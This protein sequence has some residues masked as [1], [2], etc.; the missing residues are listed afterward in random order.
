MSAH[1]A[2][3]GTSPLAE[4]GSSPLGQT[5]VPTLAHKAE[6]S[7]YKLGGSLLRFWDISG[8]GG[9]EEDLLAGPGSRTDHTANLDGAGC[10]EERDSETAGQAS[11]PQASPAVDELGS[12]EQGWV[13]REAQ[14]APRAPRA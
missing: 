7:K 2:A 1:Q 5:D 14:G 11:L 12:G 6:S 4:G 9:P 10:S 8:L 3:V 13:P